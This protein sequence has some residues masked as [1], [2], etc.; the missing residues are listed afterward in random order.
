MKWNRW[1]CFGHYKSM[2]L[3][4]CPNY[5]NTAGE[6]P[7]AAVC[8]QQQWD[9]SWPADTTD[10]QIS[11]RGKGKMCRWNTSLHWLTVWSDE[12]TSNVLPCIVLNC[13][14]VLSL[15][16]LFLIHFNWYFFF[17]TN[18][19]LG[20]CSACQHGISGSVRKTEFNTMAWNKYREYCKTEISQRFIYRLKT[21][22]FGEKVPVFYD[23]IWVQQTW[24]SDFPIQ[25]KHS[26]HTQW[27]SD[28]F[29]LCMFRSCCKYSQ[30]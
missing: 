16:P 29:I 24:L 19:N 8:P 10:R 17:V 23:H 28:V 2:F 20:L 30:M 18:R 7:T 5:Q 22:L 3:F 13:N 12:R 4:Q 27:R 9:P 11:G 15:T 1:G 25:N 26:S 21:W 6:V 14:S